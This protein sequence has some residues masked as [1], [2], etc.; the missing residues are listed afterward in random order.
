MG[1]KFGSTGKKLGFGAWGLEFGGW[2]LGSGGGGLSPAR[3]VEVGGWE[4]WVRGLV[5]S[6]QRVGEAAGCLEQRDGGLGLVC[7]GW[8]LGIGNR[9]WGSRPGVC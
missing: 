5:R 8:G 9:G 7:G 6:S 4:V 1:A 2:G 3:G